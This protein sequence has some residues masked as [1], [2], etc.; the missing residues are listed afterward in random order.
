MIS[1]AGAGGRVVAFLRLVVWRQFRDP[2]CLAG[3]DRQ[4]RGLVFF[5]RGAHVVEATKDGQ[6]EY[7]AVATHRDDALVVVGSQMSSDWNLVLTERFLTG[8]QVA[9]LRL[10]HNSV[11]K[12]APKYG[13]STHR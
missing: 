10:M 6:T 3:G 7:W 11:R 5:A 2:R 13:C 9:D 8:K 12:L 4:V 1:C